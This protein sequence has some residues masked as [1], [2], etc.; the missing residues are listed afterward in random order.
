MTNALIIIDVQN[1]FCP[2]G[3]LA[4]ADG[5]AVVPVINGMSA[6]LIVLTQDWHPKN[7]FSFASQHQGK[8]P[9]ETIECAYGTQTLWPNHCVEGSKGAEF[10]PKLNT[11][12]AHLVIRKGFNQQIDSYSAFMENDKKTATGLRSYLQERGVKKITLVG[13][14]TDYCVYYSAIDGANF[15]FECTVA[16]NACRGININDSVNTAIMDMKS[17]GIMV[18]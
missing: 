8:K 17:K 18:I 11:N 4:V 5:D 3:H 15:G 12:R 6:D 16:L 9:F 1:D 10:H 7:H 14:A 13:L 2:K